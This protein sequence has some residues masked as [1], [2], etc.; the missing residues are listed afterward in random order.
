VINKSD[1]T[2]QDIIDAV[3]DLYYDFS[4]PTASLRNIDDRIGI[5]QAAIYCLFR[6]KEEMVFMSV[7]KFNFR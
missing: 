1:A 6:N 5:T 2:L 4:Y 3:V 7:L